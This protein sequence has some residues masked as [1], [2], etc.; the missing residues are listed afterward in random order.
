MCLTLLHFVDFSKTPVT[1]VFKKTKLCLDK[2]T[3]LTVSIGTEIKG[4]KKEEEKPEEKKEKQQEISLTVT[5][6]K[7][8]RSVNDADKVRGETLSVTHNH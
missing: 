1:D 6:N 4:E 8:G 5:V 3:E 7:K 2:K